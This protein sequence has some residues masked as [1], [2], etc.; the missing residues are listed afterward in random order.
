MLLFRGR[1]AHSQEVQ[2]ESQRNSISR[3]SF[4]CGCPVCVSHAQRGL[5]RR[6]LSD[7]FT[8]FRANFLLEIASLFCLLVSVLDHRFV[9]QRIL[10]RNGY[11]A[12]H[13]FEKND[14]SSLECPLR[15]L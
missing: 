15:S 8:N 10:N 3:M 11:L 9:V 1:T 6:A 14:V 4:G 12:G 7:N 13:L 5:Q 2:E